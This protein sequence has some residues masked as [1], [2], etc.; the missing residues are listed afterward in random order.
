[1]Y[2]NVEAIL[3]KKIRIIIPIITV[4]I[5]VLVILIKKNSNDVQLEENQIQIDGRIITV[6][7]KKDEFNQYKSNY[8]MSFYENN[9]NIEIEIR[10][11]NILTYKNIKVGDNISKLD[12]CD[13]E[14]G[15]VYY[16]ESKYCS[17]KYN[18]E[19]QYGTDNKEIIT[20]TYNFY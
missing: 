7:S 19:I 11:E 2:C 13:K 12:F 4:V 1:M 5:I 10:D 18:L 8:D 9:N 3:L 14:I 20:I 17:G 15:M 6:T 16:F